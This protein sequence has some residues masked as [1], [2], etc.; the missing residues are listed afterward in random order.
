[1][2]LIILSVRM[3]QIER[4]ARDRAKVRARRRTDTPDPDTEKTEAAVSLDEAR[5]L[6]MGIIPK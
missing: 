3:E 6:A 5:S 4:E 1:M 2:K